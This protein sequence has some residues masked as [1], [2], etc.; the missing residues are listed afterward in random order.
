M[1]KI[2]LLQGGSVQHRF[3]GNGLSRQP[4]MPE[5]NEEA[6][7]FECTLKAGCVW[8]PPLFPFREKIQM[9]FFTN[10]TGFVRTE[11][12]SWNIEQ[13][14]FVPDYDREKVALHAG[15]QDLHFLHI[16]IQTV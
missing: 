16:F 11:T 12:Q 3:D 6:K 13:G 1:S 2:R 5:A 9:F 15:A 14:V 7:L 4:L 10:Q 8:E